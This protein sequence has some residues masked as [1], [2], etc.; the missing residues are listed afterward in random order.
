VRI[1][2][3]IWGVLAA[4]ILIASAVA[5][6][7]VISPLRIV[8]NPRPAFDVNVWV[9]RDET[10]DETPVYLGGEEI[11]FSVQVSEDA[12]V[13]LFNLRSDG[14]IQ[15][16]LPNRFDRA[17][18]DNF[19]PA[20][21]IRSFPPAGA[22]YAFLVEPPDGLERVLAV[23]SKRELS[24][25]ELAEFQH[26]AEFATARMDDEQFARALSIVVEPV[27]QQE[28]V[29]DT[30]LFY[31]G[32]PPAVAEFGTLRI[33]TT[34]SDALAFVDGRFV[35]YTPTTVDARPG[36]R[37]IRVEHPHYDD[38]ETTASVVGG[39]T[40]WVDATLREPQRRG[41]LVVS[42]NVGG[43]RV[44]LDGEEV[45]LLADG[46]GELRVPDMSAGQYQLRV[47]A[48]GFHDAVQT[49]TVHA[50][51]TSIAH[52][53]LERI[54]REP[55]TD[56]DAIFRHLELRPYPGASI[57][58]TREELDTVHLRFETSDPLDI[59]YEHFHAQFRDWDRV[60]LDTRPNRVTAEY[61]RG[62]T[63]L[64]LDLYRLGQSG[65]YELTVE[66]IE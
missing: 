38:F 63:T 10:G 5:Q 54:E 43:A 7:I 18:Q 24:T 41:A 36:E 27:P 42:G 6:Q 2:I 15:Q 61:R 28:W 25:Q 60:V 66:A 30:A 33:E 37:A 11:R 31:V 64:E 26:D 40:R 35:G 62:G 22:R 44:L 65:V 34:P 57:Q 51:E 48:P 3:K 14:Q 9:D 53:R 58:R 59:V 17:G 1:V 50:D 13:Y 56:D 52:V 32:E 55:V 39:E 46:S 19:L 4:S 16:I 29:T 20:G 21:E 49:V 8:V 47:T 12:Y 45:G 23:A